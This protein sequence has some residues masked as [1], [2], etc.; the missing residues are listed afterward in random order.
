M[1]SWL[2]VMNQSV[3]GINSTNSTPSR[4]TGSKSNAS[5]S[6]HASSGSNTKFPSSTATEK[7]R[8][9]RAFRTCSSGTWMKVANSSAARVGHNKASMAGPK[10]GQAVPAARPKPMASR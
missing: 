2:N 7:R 1:P 5:T 9:R 6:T 10:W 8:S 4:T 3:Q